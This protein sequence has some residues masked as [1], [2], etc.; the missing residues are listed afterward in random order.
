M[1]SQWHIVWEQIRILIYSVPATLLAIVV[2]EAA[3]GLVSHWMGDPT[4]KR[5]GRLSLNPLRH[6]DLVGTVCMVAFH[7]GWAKPVKVN[8]W[9]YRNPK[10]GMALTALAGP[11]V[12]LIMSFLALGAFVGLYYLNNGVVEGFVGYWIMFLDYFAILSLGLAIFNLIPIPPLDGSKVLGALL[13][14]RWYFTFMSFEQYG[15]VLMIALLYFGVLDVPLE[16]VRSW[17]ID[18]MM[19]V[20]I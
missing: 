12:N 14:E 4:P 13:P 11:V 18:I 2:H 20:W 19:N 17:F 7:V 16:A 10:W 9:Y 3:H 15:S 8:P 5:D 1:N 6:L